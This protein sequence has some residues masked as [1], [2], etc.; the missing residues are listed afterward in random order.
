MKKST[1]I[2]LFNKVRTTTNFYQGINLIKNLDHFEEN[3][4]IKTYK[5]TAYGYK[6]KQQKINALQIIIIIKFHF[7]CKRLKMFLIVRS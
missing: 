7:L 1:S 2:A 5:H 3:Y 6:Q 4:Y